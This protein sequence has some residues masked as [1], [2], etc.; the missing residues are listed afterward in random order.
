MNQ[1]IQIHPLWHEL[2]QTTELGKLDLRAPDSMSESQIRASILWM[3]DERVTKYLGLD[4]KGQAI[5][6]DSERKRLAEIVSD[7]DEYAWM[8]Y[9]DGTLIGNVGLNAIHEQSEIEGVR[10]ARGVILLDPDYH[11]KWIAQTVLIIATDWAFTFGGF[12]SIISR[13]RPDNA[14]SLAMARR[15]GYAPYN[16]ANADGWVWFRIGRKDWITEHRG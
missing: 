12:E 6:A 2:S 14:A 8:V 7:T 16:P 3:G 13:I 10:A 9:L 11:R 4:L 5:N 15:A 1:Y